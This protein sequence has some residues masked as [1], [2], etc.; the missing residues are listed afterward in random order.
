MD[1]LFEESSLKNAFNECV[2]RCNIEV[3]RMRPEEHISWWTD[4]KV[5]KFLKKA[6]FKK[7][8][9]SRFN[10]SISPHMRDPE[11]FDDPAIAHHS[12]YIEAIK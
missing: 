9:K 11:Y 8:L 5:I 7:V 6:D 4:E 12:L 2:K 1:K 3:Q 10:Q